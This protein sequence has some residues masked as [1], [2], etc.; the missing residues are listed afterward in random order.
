MLYRAT[1]GEYKGE[2]HSVAEWHLIIRKVTD[3]TAK[4]THVA[5]WKKGVAEGLYVKEMGKGTGAPR[6]AAIKKATAP[7]PTKTADIWT[8]HGSDCKPIKWC[9]SDPT[10]TRK[11]EY[12]K[13]EFDTEVDRDKRL[14]EIL[15]DKENYDYRSKGWGDK[16]FNV[17]Y[18]KVVKKEN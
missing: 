10:D 7:A 11:W 13:E 5:V 3:K 8:P 9:V 15:A 14:A 2:A 6:K 12:I 16:K 1:A 18:W 4:G 17:C